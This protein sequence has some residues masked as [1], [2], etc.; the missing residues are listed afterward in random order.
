M[1]RTKQFLAL[2]LTG[3]MVMSMAACG[4]GEKESSPDAPATTKEDTDN[5]EAEEGKEEKGSGEDVTIT[6][7][8]RYGS[9][10]PDEKYFR[11]KIQ[12][13][14][15]MDNG[16]KVEMD[17]IPTETDYLDNLRTGFASG[18]TPNV[19]TE[20]GGSRTLDYLE[21]DALLNMQPYYDEDPDWYN[22]FNSAVWEK[23][24]YEGYDGVWGIPFKMYTVVLYYNK[25]IFEDN[26][27]T[28]PESF[29]DLLDV[30]E[31][32][33]EKGIKPFQAG[34]KENW[35]FGHFHNNLIIKSLGTEA[36]EKLANRELAYD[37]PELMKTYETMADMVAKGYFGEDIL[38]TDPNTEK[39]T[40][41]AEESAM[42]WDGSWYVGEL[43][44]KE[45]YDKVGVIPF[46]YVNEEYKDNAQGSCS[47]MWFISTVN[48]SEEEIAASVELVKYLTSK[49]YYAGNF[50]ASA[51]LFP[52]E[53]EKTA[54]T[55][56]NP[57]M[58]DIAEIAGSMSSMKDDVQTY[59]K[60]SHMLDTVRNALQGLAMGNSAE[61]CAAQIMERIAEEE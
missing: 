3:A 1:K 44:E 29:D 39:S 42:R 17:T 20:Y 10:V 48:K 33:T 49:D 31:K 54:N 30:C 59:D 2:A 41:E 28:P 51:Q 23:L 60:S 6:I 7:A 8:S 27:L 50:E 5:K 43:R 22:S 15:D 14:S 40:F 58:D 47:D 34:E 9:D 11:E 35:R 55:P 53:F 18:D 16:I 45:I 61:E 4:G 24:Q 36:V 46:P 25:E 19:F 12:E 52:V 26:G 32:L 57:L 21:S 56:E 37:S 13:F 38:N